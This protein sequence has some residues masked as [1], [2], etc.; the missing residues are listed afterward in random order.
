MGV[1]NRDYMRPD[2]QGGSRGSGPRSWSVVTWL[3]AL[4]VAVYVLQW[5][6]APDYFLIRE[7]N[8]ELMPRGGLS[9]SELEAGKIWTLVTYMFL[10]GGPKPWH[11]IFNMFVLFFAGRNVLELLGKKHFLVVYFGGGL[12]GAVAQ[13]AFGLLMGRE[14]YLIGASAGVVATLIA[15]AALVPQLE[16]YLLVFFVIP[17]RM[18]MKT[19]AMVL[20]AFDVGTM[21]AEFIG[22]WSFGIGNL[23]HL[24]G[25]LFGWVYVKR[26]LSGAMGRKGPSN[27]EDRWQNQFGGNQEVDAEIQGERAEKKSWFKSSKNEPYISDNV[28][29]ILE[30]ISEHGMQSLS[31]EERKILEKSSEKLAKMTGRT[32]RK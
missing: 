28:D 3:I 1:Y 6:I 17:V 13:I 25:A 15:M 19:V 23:A 20:V 7:S 21:L 9:W 4:N 22:P 30:K 24:G 12:L 26:G 29:A 16:V 2:F 11:L 5:V 18:K 14:S 32:G 10:H 31:E 8:G 27:K